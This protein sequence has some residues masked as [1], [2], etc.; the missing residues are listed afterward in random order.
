MEHY[1]YR[2]NVLWH[3]ETAPLIFDCAFWDPTNFY[4]ARPSRLSLSVSCSNLFAEVSEENLTGSFIVALHLRPRRKGRDL[5]IA[6][7]H[8][9]L[10]N[11]YIYDDP[12]T[13]SRHYVTIWCRHRQKLS[14]LF[15]SVSIISNLR[16]LAHLWAQCCYV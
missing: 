15:A 13:H 12:R 7:T 10:P 6:D 11:S 9:W 2:R 8:G 4:R 3:G 5:T 14:R 1:C 16:I